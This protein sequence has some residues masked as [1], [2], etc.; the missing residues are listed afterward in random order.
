M[1]RKGSPKSLISFNVPN[2]QFRGIVS[3]QAL[4]RRFVSL[5]S[6]FLSGADLPTAPLK[7][8]PADR[9][10]QIL[11][12]GSICWVIKA[13]TFAPDAVEKRAARGRPL[14]S[15]LGVG[16]RGALPVEPTHQHVFELDELLH[17]MARAFAADARF[18]HAAE[19]R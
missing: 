10:G 14:L 19:R 12:K 11:K 1:F 2:H 13:A 3:F 18:L 17:A 8:G 15:P 6:H 5:F 4:R 16:Q 7:I 9:S